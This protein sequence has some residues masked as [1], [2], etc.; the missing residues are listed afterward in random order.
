M[1]LI[2]ITIAAFVVSG[3]AVAQGWTEYSYPDYAFKVT[4][5]DGPRIETTTYQVA[6]AH[7]IEAHVYSVSRDNA[8]FEVTI[9]ELADSGLEETAIIDY[10]IKALSAGGEVQVN[11]PHRINRVF[12][13]QLSILQTDGSRAM[14]ALFDYNG[15]LYQIVG[16]SL[17]TG[18][19]ATADTIRFVQS[20]IF[21]GGGSNRSQEEIR[22]ALASCRGTAGPGT[23]GDVGTT[24]PG[25]DRRV[26]IRCRRQQSVAALVSSLNSGDLSG[27]QQ[28]YLSLSQ[29]QNSS[30]VQ[31]P[32]RNGPFTQAMTQIG[33]ALQNGDLAGAQ[34]ALSSVQ[35]GRRGIRQP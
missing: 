28:A 33:Q 29:L 31:F 17:A 4:F 25:A 10:A 5:P 32:N 24:A 21:T 6:D 12:G 34:Q 1:R 2:A 14:V 30:Q 27:A 35:R 16:K 18:N 11:I 13:R 8:E 22:A 9:A 20:L 7:A 19:D 23:A 26:E 3:P 15:R